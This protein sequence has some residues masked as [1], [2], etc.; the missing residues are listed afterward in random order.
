MSLLR[1][2]FFGGAINSLL[3]ALV[4]WTKEERALF[5]CGPKKE[6]LPLGLLGRERGLKDRKIAS[7]RLG[8]INVGESCERR[9]LSEFSLLGGDFWG[10]E[11]YQRCWVCVG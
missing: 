2:F 4:H 9:R 1:F 3:A 11:I 6:F 10:R 8:A 7:R 5:T